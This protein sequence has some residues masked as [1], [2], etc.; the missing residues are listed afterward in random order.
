MPHRPM[1]QVRP[2]QQCLFMQQRL[3]Q[4]RRMEVTRPL[5]HMRRWLMRRISNEAFRSRALRT[6]SFT[7]QLRALSLREEARVRGSF[8]MRSDTTRQAVLIE[9]GR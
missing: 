9:D 4:L 2:M 5:Q 1:L 7:E 8:S 6:P 3:M